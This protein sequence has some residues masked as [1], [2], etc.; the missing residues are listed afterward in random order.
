MS[1]RH[2]LLGSSGCK[3]LFLRPGKDFCSFF[4]GGVRLNEVYRQ[5]KKYFM[6][7]ADMVRLAGQLE[8]VMPQALTTSSSPRLGLGLWLLRGLEI[9][10]K[11]SY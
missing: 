7:L 5:E 2:I 8:R 6:N 9:S 11:N 3:N 1:L 4:I 10:F